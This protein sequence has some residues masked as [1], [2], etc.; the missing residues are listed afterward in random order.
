[1]VRA[2]RNAGCA[3]CSP[4]IEPWVLREGER[5]RI[6]ADAFPR[7]PGHV[8]LISRTHLPVN[9]W[10][11]VDRYAE[12]A[13]GCTTVIAGDQRFVVADRA[14]AL[15]VLREAVIRHTGETLDP[16]TGGLRRGGAEQVAVTR[17]LWASWRL[18]ETAADNSPAERV[19]GPNWTHPG[20]SS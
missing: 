1:M 3:F 14:F 5:Y 17:R 10:S 4:Q 16:S 13:G 9:D 2:H 7:L 11:D 12:R 18:A 20:R 8:L 15:R 6:I 19:V